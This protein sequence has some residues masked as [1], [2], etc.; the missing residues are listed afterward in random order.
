MLKITILTIGDEICIG[1]VVNTNASWLAA[2]CT[3]LGC[4]IVAHSIV[5]DEKEIMI[6]ELNRLLPISDFIIITGGL[7]PTHDDITKPVLCEFFK[8]ELVFHEETLNQIEFL[9]KWRGLKLTERNRGQAF[10]PSKCTPLK[11]LMGTAPGMLF[12]FQN[13]YIVSLPGV[14][15]EMKGLMENEILPLISKLILIR[16]EEVV[17]FKNI[18][19][20]GIAESMLADLIGEPSEFLGNGTLAF[21]PSYKGVRLRIGVSSGNFEEARKELKII[22]DIIIKRAGKYIFAIG[23]DTLGSTVGKILKEKQLT[24]AV[25]ESCTGGLLGGEITSTEGSS[26]Y[27]KGGVIVYSNDSKINLLKVNP[28][29]IEKFGAVS[30]ETALELAEN[31]RKIFATDY[32]LSITGI[33]GPGGATPDKPVG[34]VWIGISDKVKSEAKLFTFVHDRAVNRERAVGSALGWLY[35]KIK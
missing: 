8:D 26:V 7:G 33:A 23:E 30:K 12:S 21:L 27:F 18:Q 6:S 5:G 15:A 1:Q 13:K 29:T 20:H 32:G 16:K 4:R 9:F 19:T 31:V 14:P 3:E 2:K 28:E 17:L 10:I 24:L 11:N 22:E 35:N 25:A 34:T